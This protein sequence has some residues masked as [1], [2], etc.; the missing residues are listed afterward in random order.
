MP[1][2]LFEPAIP[3]LVS[4]SDFSLSPLAKDQASYT[5]HIR[6]FFNGELVVATHAHGKN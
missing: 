1:A 4:T 5:Y 6:A 2:Q 3:V